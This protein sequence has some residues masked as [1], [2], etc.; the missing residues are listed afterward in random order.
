MTDT[1]AAIATPYGSGG[2]GGHPHL[3]PCSLLT[4]P[5]RWFQGNRTGL[6]L[7][8]KKRAVFQTVTAR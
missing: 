7:D 1:I 6:R 4:S 2:I 3:R 8:L 5:E